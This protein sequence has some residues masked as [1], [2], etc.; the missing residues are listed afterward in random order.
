MKLLGMIREDGKTADM[1]TV[2]NSLG[3]QAEPIVPVTIESDL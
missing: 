1:Y 2:T 3:F